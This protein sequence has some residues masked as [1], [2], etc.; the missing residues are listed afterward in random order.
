MKKCKYMRFSRRKFIPVNYLLGGQQL[1]LVHT[2]MDLGILLDVKLSFISH[3]NMTI[4]KARGVLAFIKRWSKE[5][6]DPYITKQL[7]TSL[8]RPI[9]EY[10]SIIWDPL[11]NV[12][13]DYIESI[14]KQFLIFCLRSLPWNPESNLT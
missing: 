11:Y 14:Q 5:F 3:I 9:L 13:I 2:F 8:V 10:G 1:E 12:H 7:Y 4:N 6:I